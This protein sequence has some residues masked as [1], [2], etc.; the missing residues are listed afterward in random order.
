[1]LSPS[2]QSSHNDPPWFNA[3]NEMIRL[4]GTRPSSASCCNASSL[5]TSVS[6]AFWFM[7]IRALA[8]T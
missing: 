6:L 2:A 8:R 7:K 1:M 4:G 3:L 5:T